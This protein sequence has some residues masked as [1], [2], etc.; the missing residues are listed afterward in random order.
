M[1]ETLTKKPVATFVEM[2]RYV[3]CIH[4]SIL[5][6]KEEAGI[7]KGGE[8]MRMVITLFFSGTAVSL[9]TYQFIEIVQA[10]IDLFDK[11]S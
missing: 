8:H 6:S 4:S 3:L 10:F 7:K 2:H 11:H 9:L 5:S 1:M